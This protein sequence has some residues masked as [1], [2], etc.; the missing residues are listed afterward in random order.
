MKRIREL[1]R[2]NNGLQ[3]QL[4]E[5]AAAQHVAEQKYAEELAAR[6]VAVE[7]AKAHEINAVKYSNICYDLQLEVKKLKADLK[8]SQHVAEI[9]KIEAE[10]I[11]AWERDRKEQG[12]IH[13]QATRE[14]LHLRREKARTKL[15]IAEVV[16][17]LEAAVQEPSLGQ[18]QILLRQIVDKLRSSFFDN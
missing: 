16:A 3:H 11:E 17:D 1:K 12:L 6:K 14:N 5:H 4:R 8:E 10:R 13:S 15:S 7:R 2:V 18:L 9:R